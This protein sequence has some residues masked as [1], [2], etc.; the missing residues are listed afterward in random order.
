LSDWFLCIG[1]VV[2]NCAADFQQGI[3]GNE[4]AARQVGWE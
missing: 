1:S 2:E 3:N 4:K